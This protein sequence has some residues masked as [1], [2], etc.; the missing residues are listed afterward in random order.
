MQE[1]EYIVILSTAGKIEEAEKIAT[2]LVSRH[3]VACVNIVPAI[4][5]IY[6]WNKSVQKDQEVLMVMKTERSK[7]EQVQK[8][9]L[10][11]H[12]YEVPEV[13]CLT[14]ED[15]SEGYLQWIKKSVQS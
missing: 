4:Q 9:I 13:I 14:L 3:L 2:E 1:S 12:S 15:G 6:W 10:E 5:S 8:M 7:W 11:L